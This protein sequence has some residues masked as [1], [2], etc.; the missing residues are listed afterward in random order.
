MDGS[1]ID[2]SL[3][4]IG[5][6][7]HPLS[8]ARPRLAV[9][10]VFA[11]AGAVLLA[12]LLTNALT[13]YGVHRDEF[14]YMAMGRHLRL[15]RMDF[16]PLIALLAEA[17]R[18]FG[19][20]LVVVRST[21]ALAGAALVVLAALVARELGGGR[22]AQ[23]L[24]G[25]AV[26]TGPLYLRPGNLFQPVVF[27]QLWWTLGLL[28]L[29][30]L[31]REGFPG[32]SRWW[33]VLGV[34]GGLG[35]LTKFSILLFGAAVL[36]ALVIAPQR[37]ALL[38]RGP[39]LAVA[40]ALVLGGPSIV[41]QMRLG[42]PVAGQMHDLE[43]AQLQ[44]VT[45]SG[46]FA[47]QVMMLGPAVALA[48]LGLAALLVARAYRPF[49]VVGWAA[50]G[51]FLLLLAL[52][53]K[54]YYAGPIYPALFGAGAA[55][56]AAWTTRIRAAGHAAGAGF[57]RGGAMLVV[58]AFGAVTLPL[59]L[60]IVPP[61]AMARY[62]AALGVSAA[63]RTN[64]GTAL[65]LPQD[66]ADMLGWQE[67]VA[68]VASAYHSLP[69]AER[70]AAVIVA[71]NYGEAGA[72]DFYGP[73]LGLPP[74]VAPVGSYW[75]FGPGD[76]PGEVIVKVGGSR[77]DLAPYCRSIAL[78]GRV[79]ARWVVPEERDLSI[80]ICRHPYRTLQAIW[81]SFAGRN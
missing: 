70:E 24:A 72:I 62:A 44:H 52:H 18:A 78:A 43:G 69:V 23:A 29:A 19:D 65:P 15:F 76:K 80:W 31:G 22:Y 50:A 5:V 67:Q 39:W 42:W 30:H 71:D 25:L 20:S 4:P 34:A 35:L 48:A 47:G 57:A 8:T 41:G 33:L 14:L 32:G 73:R 9:G 66:Y 63:T 45:Y 17:S 56:L 46:F 60:P 68:A 26:A 75:F 2:G 11:L 21:P 54:P 49:R 27:D 61:G 6:R 51:S 16:P 7:P 58:A 37:R 74:A 77:D 81:P 3:R 12:H 13:P 36:A 79:N 59:G 55:T 40:L 1:T 28:A 10:A 38:T 64:R 53:G